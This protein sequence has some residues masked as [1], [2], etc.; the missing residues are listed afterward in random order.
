M[1]APFSFELSRRAHVLRRLPE[2]PQGVL[3]GLHGYGEAAARTMEALASTGLSDHVLV[4]P[5]AG[6]HFYNRRGEVVASWMTQYEREQQVEELLEHGS[7]LIERLRSEHG[8]LPIWL[9]GFSQ[10]AA[11]AYRL[12]LLTEL[13]L[14]GVFVLAG[15]LPPEAIAALATPGRRPPFYLLWGE[16]DERVP[17]QVARADLARLRAAGIAAELESFPGGHDYLPAAMRR[18]AGRVQ[19]AL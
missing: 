15:D 4:A 9:L 16:S 14:A 5:M 1:D 7:A 10:G 11:H 18:V 19:A 2:R 17:I 8:A 6:H 3:V 12:A 13:G